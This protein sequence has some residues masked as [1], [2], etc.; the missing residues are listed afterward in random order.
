MLI[1]CA[2]RTL[3]LVWTIVNILKDSFTASCNWLIK[4]YE[5]SFSN[6]LKYSNQ[7]NLT[8]KRTSHIYN[9]IVNSVTSLFPD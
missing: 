8:Q 1:I 6:I 3:T 2:Q 7:I 9:Y 4:G 5:N